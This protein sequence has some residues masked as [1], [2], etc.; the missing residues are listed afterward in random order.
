[1]QTVQRVHNFV[2]KSV[3]DKIVNALHSLHFVQ[4]SK[5]LFFRARSARI[6]FDFAVDNAK[7]KV[8]VFVFCTTQIHIHILLCAQREFLWGYY[9]QL[10]GKQ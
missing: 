8:R 4:R 1:M 3:L 7:Q 9:T 5:Y 2:E 10:S 6:F